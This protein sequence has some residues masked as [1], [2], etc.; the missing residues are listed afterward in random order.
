MVR[1]HAEWTTSYQNW[2]LRLYTSKLSQKDSVWQWLVFVLRKSS[3][4]EALT[5]H[6]VLSTG[7]FELAPGPY[8]FEILDFCKVDVPLI[9][10]ELSRVPD[11]GLRMVGWH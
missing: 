5:E 2:F 4:L 11:F 7:G 10:S 1:Y 8:I 3:Y 6:A 9:G